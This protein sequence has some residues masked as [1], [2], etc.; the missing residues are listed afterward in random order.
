[1][2]VDVSEIIEKEEKKRI[3]S[4]EIKR[5][6][7]E[8]H[9]KDFFLTEVKNGSTY[10][11]PAQG[12]LMFDG[13]A[14]TRSYT[15]PCIKIYEVKVSR[16]DFLRDNKWN[17]YKQYC[18]ELY[19]VVPKGLIEKTE[20]P[21]DVGLIYYNREG[22]RK[23]VTKQKARWRDI[24][25]PIDVYKYLIYSRLE[26]DRI[27]FYNSRKEYAADYL[28]DKRD[29]KG[30]GYALGSKMA[31]RLQ[32]AEKKLA[33][34]QSREHQLEVLNAI[35]EV[36]RDH[37]LDPFDWNW[38]LDWMRHV[39]SN[40]RREK[41]DPEIW[42]KKIDRYKQELDAALSAGILLSDLDTLE[43]NAQVIMRTVERIR[44]ERGEDEENT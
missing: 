32:E 35:R 5:A 24:E 25:E 30:I 41:P 10:F 42:Q 12:L 43:R 8:S 7:A 3:T 27:P 1:M 28:Q 9:D 26:Q 31:E 4:T 22:T 2:S 29:R 15:K 17:L 39:W 16:S 18:N 13:F 38:D 36:L 44:K 40:G 37:G 20:L 11:P 23:L 19:F 33:E 34:L 6:L 21:D 14:M